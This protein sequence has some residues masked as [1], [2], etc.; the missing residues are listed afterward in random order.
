MDRSLFLILLQIAAFWPVWSWY[1]TRIVGSTDERWSLLSLGTV[2]V[3]LFTNRS[4]EGAIRLTVPICLI[5]LYAVTFPFSP[6]LLRAI[7]A[8]ASLAS[9]L[10]IY[11]FGT[12]LHL[13]I[14][15]LFLLS[16]PVIPTLQFYLGYPI[17]VLVASLS[18][19]LIQM[20][21]INVV[22][23]GT[24]LRLGEK[25]IWIDAPCSGVKM[26]WVGLYLVC[27]LVCI[28]RLDLKKTLLTI[29]ISLILITIGNIFRSIGLFYLEAELVPLPGWTHQGIGIV[30]FILIA[31]S[32]IFTAWYIGE[33]RSCEPQLSM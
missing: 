29:S 5:L 15:G 31:L 6:P 32:I 28:Y 11:R 19:P 25:L 13:G 9:T 7:L 14:L 12:R 33:R 26:L 4:F 23:E 1:T 8:F 21:G 17:R 27:T 16:V 24:C 20:T 18:T 3:L 30:S 10:S 22:R 2:L